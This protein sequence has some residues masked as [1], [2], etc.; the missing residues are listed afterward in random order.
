MKKISYPLVLTS[1]LLASFLVFMSLAGCTKT[2]TTTAAT[3]TTTTTT[4]VQPI[5]TYTVGL[6]A[7][8]TGFLGSYNTATVNEAQIAVDMVNENGGVIVGG[9]NYNLKL[10]VE[11]GQSTLDGTTAAANKL[12]FNDNVKIIIGPDAYFNSAVSGL[13]EQNKILHIAGYCTMQPGEMDATTTYTFLGQAASINYF[14]GALAYLKANYPNVKTVALAMPDDGS[15][16]YFGAAVQKMVQA[17]GYTVAGSIIGYNNSAVDFS[18][19][20]AKIIATGAD[21]VICCSGIALPNGSILK[22]VRDAGSNMLFVI[23]NS[24]IPTDNIKVAGTTESTNVVDCSA[25]YIGCPNPSAILTEMIQ[26]YQL[27]VGNSNA[28]LVTLEYANPIW[29]LGQVLNQANS[30]DP[31]VLKNTFSNMTSIQTLYG[32]G[33]ISGLKTFGIN[34]AVSYQL[35]ITTIT[36]GVPTFQ[37]WEP[38]LVP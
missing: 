6:L 36:N 9:Q 11:D 30:F 8:L 25:A 16:P 35:P 29:E 33:T 27:L 26:R 21:A 34:Q 1:I 38:A 37:T 4:T 22:D 32:P 19:Y 10:V 12:I 20:A 23:C 15:I 18:P 2:A 3:T 31:A 13:C 5:K 24:T 28:P 7:E 14:T 17:A